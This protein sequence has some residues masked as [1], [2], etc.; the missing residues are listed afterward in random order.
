[1]YTAHFSPQHLSMM[2]YQSMQS[3]DNDFGM[4][5]ANV[6]AQA[7]PAITGFA[8]DGSVLGCAGLWLRHGG[9][10]ECWT[11]L[12]RTCVGSTM[13]PVTRAVRRFLNDRDEHRIQALVLSGWS[14]GRRWVEML[15]FQYE[16]TLLRY[17]PTAKDCDMYS[18]PGGQYAGR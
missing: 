4:E 15:G 10:A 9:V 8:D 2:D 12:S 11:V 6:L 7:G 5:E 1:M 14:A 18:R 13:V 3:G 16:G 17:T